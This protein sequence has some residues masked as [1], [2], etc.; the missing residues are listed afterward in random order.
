M[1]LSSCPSQQVSSKWLA[2]D[3]FCKWQLQ[4]DFG[5]GCQ[6][7]QVDWKHYRIFIIH[8]V[9]VFRAKQREGYQLKWRE[10]KKYIGSIFSNISQISLPENGTSKENWQQKMKISVQFILVYIPDTRNWVITIPLITY[11]T[12]IR[13]QT[14]HYLIFSFQ[15]PYNKIASLQMSTWSWRIFPIL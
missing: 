2:R 3:P 8:C 11:G 10:N 13:Y 14:H 15:C 1:L 9:S 12:P 5:H 6:E 4:G 7:T